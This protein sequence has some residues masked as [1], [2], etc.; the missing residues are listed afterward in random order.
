M[1]L[2]AFLRKA[3][4]HEGDEPVLESSTVFKRLLAIGMLGALAFLLSPEPTLGQTALKEKPPGYN[5]RFPPLPDKIQRLDAYRQRRERAG[6]LSKFV[7]WAAET[8]AYEEEGGMIIDMP[9]QGPVRSFFSSKPTIIQSG[10]VTIV[11]KPILT[12]TPSEEQSA[13]PP[14]Q[15]SKEISSERPVDANVKQA[16][17]SSS[18]KNEL[19]HEL[20]VPSASDPSLP[21]LPEQVKAVPRKPKVPMLRRIPEFPSTSVDDAIQQVD[22][23]EKTPP[24][25][26]PSVRGFQQAVAMEALV[27]PKP[28]NEPELKPIVVKPERKT[29]PVQAAK[30]RTEVAPTP[31]KTSVPRKLPNIVEEKKKTTV[32]TKP[33]AAS[34]PAMKPTPR[35]ATKQPTPAPASRAIVAGER[36]TTGGAAHRRPSMVRSDIRQTGN[37][38]GNK[39]VGNKTVIA[40]AAPLKSEATSA[41]DSGEPT[42]RNLPELETSK[43]L[44]P[45]PT[46]AEVVENQRKFEEA[47]LK[48]SKKASEPKP[49][50]PSDLTLPTEP[51]QEESAA[52]PVQIADESPSTVPSEPSSVAADEPMNSAPAEINA[53]EEPVPTMEVASPAAPL[54]MPTE[55]VEPAEAPVAPAPIAQT[56]P[57]PTPPPTPMPVAA[58]PT[59][60]PAPSVEPASPPVMVME[61]PTPQVNE[62]VPPAAPHTM[63]REEAIAGLEATLP[64]EPTATSSV[65][66]SV[67]YEPMPA[68]TGSPMPSSPPPKNVILKPAMDPALA[69]AQLELESMV[70]GV[71]TPNSMETSLQ[72]AQD[73][74]EALVQ[75]RPIPKTTSPNMPIATAEE[76]LEAES[77]LADLARQKG[78]RPGPA[79]IIAPPALPSS[80]NRPTQVVPKATSSTIP[81]QPAKSVV[82]QVKKESPKS[83]TES[84]PIPDSVKP[85]SPSPP[86][87]KGE[88]TPSASSVKKNSVVDSMKEKM[89]TLPDLPSQVE[90]ST[91]RSSDE[92]KMSEKLTVGNETSTSFADDRPPLKTTDV[93]KL[94]EEIKKSKKASPNPSSLANTAKGTKDSGTSSSASTSAAKVA[95]SSPK[96]DVAMDAPKK[97]KSV[98]APKA[99][100]ADVVK[101]T[102]ATIEKQ[103]PL[104]ASVKPQA[105]TKIAKSAIPAAPPK[106]D[107]KNVATKP[108]ATEV[109]TPPLSPLPNMAEVANTQNKPKQPAEKM[110]SVSSLPPKI[111]PI[112]PL[113]VVAKDESGK[114]AADKPK[115]PTAPLPGGL[116]FGLQAIEQ[117]LLDATKPSKDLASS[118]NAKPAN[119]PSARFNIAKLESFD[120]PSSKSPPKPASLGRPKGTPGL[121]PKDAIPL[122]PD[123]ESV[124]EDPTNPTPFNDHHA[125]KM[126]KA[127]KESPNCEAPLRDLTQMEYWYRAPGAVDAVSQ[128]ARNNSDIALRI[129]ATRLLGTVPLTM[130]EATNSLKALAK[131]ATEPNVRETAEALLSERLASLPRSALR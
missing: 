44:P 68:M 127:I 28:D 27:E 2:C 60:I 47:L 9:S 39:A 42:P 119:K 35:V 93:T 56:V 113:D 96:T 37:T 117:G 11:E 107:P 98:A 36:P 91:K 43:D 79:K 23:V 116:T 123:D 108:L 63:S 67:P 118:D 15:V 3:F 6:L 34:K 76:L 51:L 29:A 114:K 110:P 73:E 87:A 49:E 30:P 20:V 45:L 64:L 94:A 126:I 40:A 69:E 104:P 61:T 99:K 66:P 62:S 10:S 105:E 24:H 102:P 70:H 92:M 55:E 89:P 38:S 25:D 121:N 1:S 78:P 58:E 33:K 112:A 111:D 72:T 53:V 31:A 77:E 41:K 106:A 32:S 115:N 90:D 19:V 100:T 5:H 26:L 12:I 131:E 82:S 7:F 22:N 86:I 80:M 8:G 128:V 57:M 71:K 48:V 120:D 109:G 4:F 130:S 84:K 95:K 75:G 50:C 81:K 74:L 54:E 88:P 17:A 16:S 125:A 122:V 52:P 101:K 46:E 83:V 124:I 21:P 103:S 97:E 85:P 14:K 13:E 129:Q 18:N 59:P 65:P